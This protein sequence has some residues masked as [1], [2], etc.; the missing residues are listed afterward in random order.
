MS[1]K[2]R[3]G[4]TI[5]VLL[6]T[7]SVVVGWGSSLESPYAQ[8][9]A[10]NVGTGIVLFALLYLVQQSVL[11]QVK[12]V[13]KRTKSSVETLTDVV[14][15]VRQ[16]VE[17]T[18]A[19]LGDLGVQTREVLEDQVAETS[20]LFEEFR[21]DVSRDTTLNILTAASALGGVS[22]DGV[23]VQMPAT[24]VWVRFR[25]I[26][27]AYLESGS[28]WPGDQH[29]QMDAVDLIWLL[30][31]DIDGTVLDTVT[32]QQQVAATELMVSVASA[33]QRSGRYPGGASF[34]PDTLFKGL[35]H[36][37]DV[38]VQARTRTGPYP[39]DLGAI[40]ELPND[41]WAI[42]DYGLESLTR[43]YVIDR[44]RFKENWLPQMN[45]KSWTDIDKF[46][47]AFTVAQALYPPRGE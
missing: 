45:T 7:G 25:W 43:R 20:R 41:E 18:K 17:E 44:S 9:L 46:D 42:T 29:P 21:Q 4:A 37:L 16:D 2:S 47:E 15:E 40:V 26:R 13:E 14:E 10:L 30:L 1:H 36:L 33:L 5:I 28:S 6:V 24:D 39:H 11:D 32:W 38:A 8:G 31:E 35:M 34:D 22:A 23:R 19:R 27:G 12:E 3:R